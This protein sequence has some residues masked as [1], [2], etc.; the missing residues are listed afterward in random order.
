MKALM[1]VEINSFEYKMD[2]KYRGF[3]IILNHENFDENLDL[4]SREGTNVDAVSLQK[5]FQRFGFFSIIYKDLSF[6][7][8]YNKLKQLAEINHQNMDC[9]AVTILTHGDL[10]CLYARDTH[11]NLNKLV[12]LFSSNKCPGLAG[13]PKLFIVQACQGSMSDPG[14]VLVS[15]QFDSKYKKSYSIPNHADFLIAQSTI[16]GFYS[17]RHPKNGSWFIQSL[18][19][20]L[21]IYGD[22][23]DFMTI[24]T[25]TCQYV[26]TDFSSTNPF[27]KNMDKQKQIP[28]ITSMLTR[29]IYFQQNKKI[30]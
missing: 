13:K 6:S 30:A 23:F 12:R 3:A 26:A 20:A 16:P 9:I 24:L 8:L 14:I 27:D 17:W 25:I 28:C 4:E 29:S 19:K 11:Y 10:G 5:Q 22:R 2:H 1:S 15:D 21:R 7:K 18:C